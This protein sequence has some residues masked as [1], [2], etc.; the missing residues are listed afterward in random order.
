[1]KKKTK[2]PTKPADTTAQPDNVL[3]LAP[4]EPDPWRHN[5]QNLLEKNPQKYHGILDA[6]RAGTPTETIAEEFAVSLT[7]VF[8]IRKRHAAELPSYRDLQAMKTARVTD[9]IIDKYSEALEKGEV[10]PNMLPL[11]YCQFV[12]KHLL[13]TG[14]PTSI[15]SHQKSEPT[16]QDVQDYLAS[17]P[18]L[19]VEHLPENPPQLPENS[20]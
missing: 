5:V 1:M 15:V 12:D 11:A 9:R 18:E 7:T 20:E 10:S 17:I 13:L 4:V 3:T 14:Q 16:V 19:E 8:Q 6:L 2:T